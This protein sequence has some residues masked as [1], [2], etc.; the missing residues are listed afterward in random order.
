MYQATEQTYFSNAKASIIFQGIHY[1]PR[2][3]AEIELLE[4]A[5]KAGLVK[6]VGE[7]E[8]IVKV[9]KVEAKESVKT[10]EADTTTA[11]TNPQTYNDLQE[12]FYAKFNKTIP[13]NKK[14]DIE[15]IEKKLA[16]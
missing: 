15:R 4:D 6:K 3:S 8:N 2:N 7:V 9:A 1:T 13:A 16:E 12:R 14:N 11:T 10:I 5:V